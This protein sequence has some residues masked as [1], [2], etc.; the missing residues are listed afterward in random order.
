MRML[1]LYHKQKHSYEHCEIASPAFAW[2]MHMRRK[3][4]FSQKWTW[5]YDI[6]FTE[7]SRTLPIEH[8]CMC[9]YVQLLH[10]RSDVTIRRMTKF[11]FRRCG[12]VRV[13]F[14][15]NEIGY[16]R[17]IFL[18]FALKLL[19]DGCFSFWKFGFFRVWYSVVDLILH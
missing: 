14:S 8:M 9:I 10:N 5:T 15:G 7:S 13:H 2:W 16:C 11:G 17:V 3:S 12:R 4:H 1:L 19:N 18:G 6:L